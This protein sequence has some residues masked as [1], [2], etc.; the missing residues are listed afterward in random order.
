M[1]SKIILVGSQILPLDHQD[2]FIYCLEVSM[3][4]NQWE[5]LRWKTVNSMILANN[6]TKWV[7]SQL[8]G[9]ATAKLGH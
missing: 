5:R 2:F 9:C 7:S 8:F 4:S 6:N 1:E 3:N